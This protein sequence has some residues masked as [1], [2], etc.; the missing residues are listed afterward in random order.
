MTDLS[1]NFVR[2]YNTVSTISD[3]CCTVELGVIA[4]LKQNQKHIQTLDSLLFPFSVPT[5]WFWL[6]GGDHL[7]M[8]AHYDTFAYCRCMWVKQSFSWETSASALEYGIPPPHCLCCA[9]GTV[10]GT[11][12]LEVLKCCSLHVTGAHW[13]QAIHGEGSLQW[14]DW[15]WIVVTITG[16]QVWQEEHRLL[17]LASHR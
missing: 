15:S 13:R 6:G 2:H 3:S 12:A 7:S 11:C 17:H 8:L 16:W 14:E 5:V 9:G 1:W 4:G 10:Q